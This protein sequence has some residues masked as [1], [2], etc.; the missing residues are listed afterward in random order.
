[1]KSYISEI[2][3]HLTFQVPNRPNSRPQCAS[4]RMKCSNAASHRQA[5]L[6]ASPSDVLES[7]QGSANI[8]TVATPPAVPPQPF[9]YQF[10]PLL[11]PECHA[12][13]RVR[14]QKG[15]IVP[16]VAL[17]AVNIAPR[18]AVRACM[19]RKSDRRPDQPFLARIFFKNSHIGAICRLVYA[20]W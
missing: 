16:E 2:P 8:S 11:V 19:R 12:P 1:M 14:E 9:S 13:G 7:S 18:G 20:V 10:L 15:V 17:L 3:E 5:S 6:V 4:S